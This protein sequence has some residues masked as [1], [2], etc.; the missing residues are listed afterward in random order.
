M[1]SVSEYGNRRLCTCCRNGVCVAIASA[2]CIG[3]SKPN[4]WR[5][6]REDDLEGSTGDLGGRKNHGTDLHRWSGGKGTAERKRGSQPHGTL[7]G[8]RDCAATRESDP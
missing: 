3:K 7:H 2:V 4:V 8:R 5:R 1:Q 6:I